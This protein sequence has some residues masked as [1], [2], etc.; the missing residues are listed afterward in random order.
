MEAFR[1]TVGRL[2]QRNR[3][4]DSCRF[5]QERSSTFIPKCVFH[6]SHRPAQPQAD[7]YER[8]ERVLGSY[9]VRPPGP[10]IRPPP[11]RWPVSTSTT[12]TLRIRTEVLQT[13]GRSRYLARSEE[14]TSELQS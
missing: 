10:L 7:R 1:R 13:H 2:S 3:S 9:G 5:R 11:G 4:A 14:H 8:D 6:N 12:P